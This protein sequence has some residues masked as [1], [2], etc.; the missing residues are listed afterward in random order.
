MNQLLRAN[1]FAKLQRTFDRSQLQFFCFFS[2][3]GKIFPEKWGLRQ[4]AVQALVKLDHYFL[5]IP[6]FWRL[7]FKFL[8]I[9]ETRKPNEQ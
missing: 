2:I 8:L 5:K 9:A 4:K 1:D 6:G 7:G 3:L